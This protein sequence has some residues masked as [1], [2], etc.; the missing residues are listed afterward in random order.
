MKQYLSNAFSL[1]MQGDFYA[2]TAPISIEDVPKN[3]IS[4]VGH[5]DVAS[6]LS[7]LL[8]TD[9]PVNRVSVS[10]QPG[11]ILYVGQYIGPR[12]PEGATKLPSGAKIKWYRVDIYGPY[13]VPSRLLSKAI[14][15]LVNEGADVSEFV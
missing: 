8:D 9:V 7:T 5:A 14:G 6:V 10:L 15:A 3:F 13:S 11:D 2:E 1:Q 12:L 4:I